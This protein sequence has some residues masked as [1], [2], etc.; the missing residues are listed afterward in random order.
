MFSSDCQAILSKGSFTRLSRHVNLLHKTPQSV[1]KARTYASTAVCTHLGVGYSSLPCQMFVI[2]SNHITFW[3]Y[4]PFPSQF[5]SFVMPLTFV[6]DKKRWK[7]LHFV[8]IIT[9]CSFVFYRYGVPQLFILPVC[10][11][12]LAY[13]HSWSCRN[14]TSQM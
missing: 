6:N 11:T 4:H 9:I 13:F 10:L 5:R 2:S 8:L 12:V 14:F 3:Q 7:S 1:H